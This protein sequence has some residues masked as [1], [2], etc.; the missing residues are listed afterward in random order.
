MSTGTAL[1]AGGVMGYLGAR[2]A[3]KNAKAAQK[4]QLLEFWEQQNNRQKVKDQYNDTR[5]SWEKYSPQYLEGATMEGDLATSL[6]QNDSAWQ[7]YLSNEGTGSLGLGYRKAT[8]S[9]MPELYGQTMP[10][11][12]DMQRQVLPSARSTAI[13]QG[14]YGGARDYLTRERLVEDAQNTVIS[15]GLQDLQNQRAQTANLLSA[16]SESL[17]R[18]LNTALTP[19]QLQMQ[20]AQ[21]KQYTSDYLWNLATQ[22]GNAVG[23]GYT[24]YS[25]IVPESYRTQGAI[26]GFGTGLS[27]ASSLGGGGY[28]GFSGLGTTGSSGVQSYGGGTSSGSMNGKYLGS[29]S[30]R[31]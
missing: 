16:D 19:A 28:G 25:T 23:L 4:S 6:A 24:P 22:F 9:I 3:N 31:S 26:N 20:S 27:I 2:S 29:S 30:W 18:Y 12:Q 21:D 13:D 8:E 1:A 17:N 14:A 7:N 10:I 15:Q 5:K 11:V